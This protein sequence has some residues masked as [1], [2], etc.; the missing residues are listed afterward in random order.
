MSNNRIAASKR[1]TVLDDIAAEHASLIVHAGARELLGVA[2][3]AVVDDRVRHGLRS[4]L[5]G[6]GARA[7]AVRMQI[8]IRPPG[9]HVNPAIL[10]RTAKQQ[11]RRHRA[12]AAAGRS[13]RS[14]AGSC[15]G[16]APRGNAPSAP[17]RRG[18]EAG[19]G[20]GASMRA[21]IQRVSSAQVDM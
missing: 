16:S 19:L 20:K 17:L 14:G 2:G 18:K 8:V 3:P 7:A 9:I 6:G 21:V 4:L 13:R 10:N 15:D 12:K 5:R 11:H 1:N